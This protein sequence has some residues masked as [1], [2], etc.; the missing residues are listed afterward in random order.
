MSG[1]PEPSLVGVLALVAL[2]LPATPAI[3]QGPWQSYPAKLVCGP[4]ATPP[5]AQLSDG[6]YKTVVDIHNPNYLFDAT[7]LPVSVLVY[8]KIAL[9]APQGEMPVPPSCTIPEGLRGDY[10]LQIDCA[11]TKSQLTLSGMPTTGAIEGFVV[12]T[13]PPQPLLDDLVPLLDVV[14]VHTPPGRPRAR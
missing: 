1:I 13:V 6:R 5:P 3:G 4:H 14:A 9:S 10:S 2:A 12:L 7:G 8:R 11:A